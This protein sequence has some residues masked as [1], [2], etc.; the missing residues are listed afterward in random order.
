MN[1]STLAFP[2]MTS[3]LGA[4]T[5]PMG[6]PNMDGLSPETF[7]A[8]VIAANPNAKSSAGIPY[9][10]IPGI[11]ILNGYLAQNPN[12]VTKKGVPYKAYLPDTGLNAPQAPT[13][14]PA[15]TV[16]SAGQSL[17]T[18][19][20]SGAQAISN[21]F[22]PGA[23]DAFGSELAHLQQPN[24]KYAPAPSGEQLGGAALETA[25][26]PAA[27]VLAP[28]SVLGRLGV[29][30][31]V[32]AATGAGSAMTNNAPM[33]QVAENAGIGG[34]V[35]LATGGLGEIGGGILSKI[36]GRSGE[37][38][39]GALSRSTKSVQNKLLENSTPT[40]NPIK[41]LLENDLVKTL[42]VGPEAR[43][44]ATQT[45]A[46]LQS[47]IDAEEA[48]TNEITKRMPGGIPV[49][50]WR[51]DLHAAVDAD[52]KLKGTGGV[53]SAHAQV[54]NI[55]DSFAHS[56]KGTDGI[57]PWAD[58][59]NVRTQMNKAPFDPEKTNVRNLIGSDARTRLFSSP[60]GGAQLQ[61]SLQNEAELIKALNFVRPGDTG[62]LHGA[63]VKGGGLGRYFAK[64]LG[65]MAGGAVGSIGGPIGEAAGGMVGG[66][67]T[68]KLVQ[69]LQQNYFDPLGAAKAQNIQGAFGQRGA[70]GASGLISQLL[71]RA[72][73]STIGQ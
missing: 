63:I 40:T 65:G 68:D 72:G 44:D 31:G 22:A 58:V 3:N 56:S 66:A 14:A 4:T 43:V 51:A 8:Q 23:S 18:P 54:D 16:G 5:T 25:A 62:T 34:G 32:G 49:E 57:I 73:V 29:T 2:Q 70:Q 12:A 55:L 64:L 69:S 20:S 9:S 6:T 17:G 35:G 48:N 11:T 53:P 19:D 33:N 13:P 59:D 47:A 36:A 52:Q 61:S 60:N 7:K 21:F 37:E 1:P 26:L 50:Q 46:H 15:P 27:A 71:A 45:A 38:A 67:A 42:S 41:T 10:Q 30:A 39:L 28:E 24:N